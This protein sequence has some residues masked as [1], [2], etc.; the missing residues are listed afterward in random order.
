M[1]VRHHPG[2]LPSH[3]GEEKERVK[4][5]QE[6]IVQVVQVSRPGGPVARLIGAATAP[7]TQPAQRLDHPLE[8]AITGTPS[9]SAHIECA[10]ASTRA[11]APSCYGR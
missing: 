10:G 1:A 7:G 4:L 11:V 9:A 2:R 3:Q 8:H 5:L 6:F